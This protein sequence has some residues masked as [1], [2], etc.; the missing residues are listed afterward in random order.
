M[1]PHN[2]CALLMGR[3]RDGE[4]AA[5]REVFVRFAARLAGVARCH[6]DAR[7]AVKV[8]PEDVVQSAYK[9]FFIRQR[10]GELDV[11][12]WDG[13]WGLLTMITLR[14]CAD[15]AAYYRAGKRDVSRETAGGSGDSG[16]AVAE[17]ALDRE[18]L[19]DEAAALAETVDVLFRTINDPDERS[20]LE[21]SLQGH[22][23]TEISALLGRAERSVRRL[24]EHI[25]KRLERLRAGAE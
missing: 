22:T 16:P 9:S 19:P 24:R 11:G 18:P 7:L 14:K 25:R 3:L 1:F 23:A 13:L 5:A 20:V 6:L 12:T 17:L 10:D 2:S 8:D 15:R 21:L 4:D